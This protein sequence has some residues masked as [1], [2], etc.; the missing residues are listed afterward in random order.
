MAKTYKGSCLCGAVNYT[1]GGPIRDV[2]ACHC[3]QCRKQTGHHYATTNIVDEQLKV[4][5]LQYITWY[6]AS[7]DAKR[8]FCRICGSALFWK[9]HSDP[10]TSIL[11]GS[12]DGA[13][14]LKLEKHIYCADKGDYYEI[15]D[16]LP[17][18][19]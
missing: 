5:G 9:R 15:A 18:H 12:L 14:G 16:G 7:D 19:P 4:T 10:H 8:G 17:Q 2:I 3:T 1:A 6:H 13:T 11:A